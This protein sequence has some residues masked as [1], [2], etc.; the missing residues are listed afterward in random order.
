MAAI[1]GYM[2]YFFGCQTCVHHFLAMAKN[3]T[4]ADKTSEG[5][6][7]WL[8][9]A[10]NSANL[11]LHGD[12][13]E[14]PRHPKVQFPPKYLCNSCYKGDKLVDKN[15]L[16]FLIAFYGRDGII[17]SEG[18]STER[19][20]QLV[21]EHDDKALDWWELQQR[22]KDLEKIKELRVSK[23]ERLKQKRKQLRENNIIKDARVN[24]EGFEDI[25][26]SKPGIIQGWGFNQIDI[27]LCVS[28]YLMCAF[29]LLVLYYHF[30]VR[31]KHRPC[32][33]FLPKKPTV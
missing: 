29:I 21:L 9:R 22:R 19:N 15:I 6:V 11:R 18:E 25:K 8:W 7:M 4:A 17:Q 3:I 23:L 28:F 24:L 14:D 5:A 2:R 26:N 20:E 27:G 12:I 10:H 30:I 16:Q 1:Q 32:Q 31:K 33:I 13:S